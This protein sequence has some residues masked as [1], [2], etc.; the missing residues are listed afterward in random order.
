VQLLLIDIFPMDIR[1][2]VTS[3][4]SNIMYLFA[5]CFKQGFPL[6]ALLQVDYGPIAD[7]EGKGPP[8]F[9]RI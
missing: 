1:A 6:G 7:T 4:L 2:P 3:E 8:L 9:V 5:A